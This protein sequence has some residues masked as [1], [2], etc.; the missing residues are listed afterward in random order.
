MA[1]RVEL[2]EETVVVVGEWR[3]PVLERP[4]ERKGVVTVTRMEQFLEAVE[5]DRPVAWDFL[6][7]MG[8]AGVLVAIVQGL[9]RPAEPR[10]LEAPG[11]PVRPE[12]LRMV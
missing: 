8:V 6:Q 9:H 11:G 7:Y 5:E 1:G 2:P 4:E 10:F 12:P 3:A